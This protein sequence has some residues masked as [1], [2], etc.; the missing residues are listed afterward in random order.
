MEAV[1][2]QSLVAVRALFLR[3]LLTFVKQGR[4]VNFKDES[5]NSTKL[6]FQLQLTSQRS[7]RI[8]I[9]LTKNSDIPYKIRNERSSYVNVRVAISIRLETVKCMIDR[10]LETRR[11][12]VMHEDRVEH[13]FFPKLRERKIIYMYQKCTHV[14]DKRGADFFVMIYDNARNKKRI[15]LQIKSSLVY[16]DKHLKKFPAIPCVVVN[17]ATTYESFYEEFMGEL[18]RCGFM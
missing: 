2:T 6:I 17:D 4:I 8:F 1:Q 10:F 18:K 11:I 12:G 13:E 16:K 9:D 7:F 5:P 3:V 15:P 14:Y